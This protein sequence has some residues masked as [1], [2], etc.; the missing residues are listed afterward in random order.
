MKYIV[1][2][3]EKKTAASGKS[4]IKATVQDGMGDSH[5][6]TIFST[7]PDFETITFESVLEA[8]MQVEND[9]KYGESKKLWPPKSNKPSGGGMMG[10][11][12]EQK[13]QAIGK[14]QD[15]KEEG[16]RVSSTFRDASMIVSAQIHGGMLRTEMDIKDEWKKWRKW[17]WSHY[18]HEEN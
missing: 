11:V 17:L 10:K 1:K 5:N 16:I 14:A 6:V 9:P 13:A 7:F 2:T 12:M 8:D 4:Y 3:L 18:E 15:R